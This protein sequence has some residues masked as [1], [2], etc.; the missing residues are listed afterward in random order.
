KIAVLV[1][2]KGVPDPAP[3]SEVA[4]LSGA[5]LQ[6]LRP[7]KILETVEIKAAT[8]KDS[9]KIQVKLA[10]IPGIHRLAVALFKPTET[11]KAESKGGKWE[12]G[13]QLAFQAVLVSPKFLFRV[14]LDDRPDAN[15][16]HP[17]TEFQLASRLSYFLWSTTPDEELLSLAGKGQLTA[18]LDKQ[19][20]R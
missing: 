14:E 20:Q 10:G 6:G 7:F 18:N 5:A 9:Q 8:E 2:G 15:E 1:C 13:M 16:A 11:K 3:D 17:I 12:A 4:K 19:V